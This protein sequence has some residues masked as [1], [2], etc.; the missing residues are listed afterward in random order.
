M[1]QLI[2]KKGIKYLDAEELVCFLQEHPR[3]RYKVCYL[4]SVK[5]SLTLTFDV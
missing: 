1:F 2:G 3:L 4:G 5:T